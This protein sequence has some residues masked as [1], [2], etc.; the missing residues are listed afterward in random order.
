MSEAQL[1][2]MVRR[3]PE[4][5]AL[6]RRIRAAS[7]FTGFER[8]EARGLVV[9]RRGLYRLTTHGAYECELEQRLSRLARPRTYL[10][11]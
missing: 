6:A 1:L 5:R 11:L 8:L 3:Y 4:P 10:P 7:L 9:R 2:F